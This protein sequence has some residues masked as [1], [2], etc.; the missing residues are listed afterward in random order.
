MIQ[1]AHSFLSVLIALQFLATDVAADQ[2]NERRLID[3]YR[4]VCQAQVQVASCQKQLKAFRFEAIQQLYRDGNAS[5]LESQKS[6]LAHQQEIVRHSYIEE[7]HL[8][9]DQ[10]AKEIKGLG[11]NE[12]RFSAIKVF[13]PGSN[14]MVGWVD[15]LQLDGQV[16][17][18]QLGD[19]K[20]EISLRINQLASAKSKLGGATD[21][22][23]HKKM[24]L[25]ASLAEARLK[26]SQ[27]KF[28]Y[29]TNL[30]AQQ[31]K[32]P[33]HLKSVKRTLRPEYDQGL[34]SIVRQIAAVEA[35]ADGD[36][37]RLSL[38]LQ[39]E[40][41]RLDS[42]GKLAKEGYAT[43][44]EIQNF[45]K[46]V[47]DLESAVSNRRVDQENLATV[48]QLQGPLDS[49]PGEFKSYQ[50]VSDWPAEVFANTNQIQY[51]IEQRRACYI[52]KAKLEIALLQLNLNQTI[53]KK[54]E[55]SFA[56]FESKQ[57][58]GSAKMVRLLSD[59]Q[60]KEINSYAWK[61]EALKSDIRAAEE[62]VQI[63]T[64]EESRFLKQVSLTNSLPDLVDESIESD[65]VNIEMN[66]A[67]LNTFLWQ[68]KRPTSSN[69]GSNKQ[70]R[71]GYVESNIID[72][73][74]IDVGLV[75][76]QT[77][78]YPLGRFEDDDELLRP[79]QLIDY[80]NRM[81]YSPSRSYRLQVGPNYSGTLYTND[82]R[83]A[84]SV[85]SNRIIAAPSLYNS[86][87]ATDAY[88][89][90]QIESPRFHFH[91]YPFGILRSDY[92]RF[93]TPGQPPW[94]L[95]GSPNNLRYNQLRTDALRSPNG[96]TGNQ[97]L[98]SK[99]YLD[100]S[101]PYYGSN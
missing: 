44:A 5:W 95:P 37:Q 32:Q 100:L 30:V 64:L 10:V 97:M 66:V 59:G 94:L 48:A 82:H 21:P 11:S 28:E 1:R 7:F 70:L 76:L 35:A 51:L 79:V 63:L 89:Q 31:S 33:Q 60:K 54:L 98:K 61:V 8:F 99:N 27:A 19:V 50:S 57:G 62:K 45:Q 38:Q 49:L 71:F 43:D 101:R 25:N 72:H 13:L 16:N 12:H 73:I 17:E 87:Y 23:W 88:R 29:L 42:L 69:A 80:S 55:Q 68:P 34:L 24:K 3:S 41:E 96:K 6:K 83:Y 85:T 86:P 20:S 9:V 81:S 47:A 58:S 91:V 77:C 90:N 18:V 75:M 22:Q 46:R 67:L 53:L 40:Q 14:R 26:L 74:G 52:Q 15:G 56:K 84:R 78:G 39:R 4:S 92:R 2:S 93:A 65:V 36:I